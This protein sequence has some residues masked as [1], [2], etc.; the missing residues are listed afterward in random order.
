MKNES[1][2]DMM[3]NDRNNRLFNFHSNYRKPFDQLIKF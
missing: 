1:S 3:I 2:A